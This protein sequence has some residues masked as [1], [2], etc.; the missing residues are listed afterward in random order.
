MKGMPKMSDSAM[1]KNSAMMKP[2]KGPRKGIGI[3][4]VIGGKP[5]KP[6]RKSAK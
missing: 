2:Q 6:P 5:P 3:I 1:M 4:L